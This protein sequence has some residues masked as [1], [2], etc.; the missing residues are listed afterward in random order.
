VPVLLT[1]AA[2]PVV[3][4]LLMAVT[5]IEALLPTDEHPDLPS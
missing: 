3:A 4:L 2:L 5:R 1:I